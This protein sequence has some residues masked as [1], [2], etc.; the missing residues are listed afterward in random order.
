MVASEDVRF[1]GRK[2]YPPALLPASHRLDRLASVRFLAPG[3]RKCIAL[4]FSQ[5]RQGMGGL[6]GRELS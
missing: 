3:L 2:Q 1:Q 5:V 4:P 6:G